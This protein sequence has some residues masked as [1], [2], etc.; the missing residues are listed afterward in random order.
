MKRTIFNT[1]ISKTAGAYL[2]YSARSNIVL[3]P[4]AKVVNK[5]A[6]K[7]PTISTNMSDFLNKFHSVFKENFN[8]ALKK[9]VE[10]ERE[11]CDKKIQ[12]GTRNLDENIEVD[13]I[14]N[15]ETSKILIFYYKN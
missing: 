15:E 14:F 10:I 13:L 11:K 5:T 2:N 4:K 8:N 7:K 1:T 3:E 9:V 12:L 6:I